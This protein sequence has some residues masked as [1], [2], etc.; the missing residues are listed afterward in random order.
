MIYGLIIYFYTAFLYLIKN[1]IVM[2]I[3]KHII[4]LNMSYQE[5]IMLYK[6]KLIGTNCLYNRFVYFDLIKKSVHWRYDASMFTETSDL[7]GYV[8]IPTTHNLLGPIKH[9][10]KKSYYVGDL[11]NEEYST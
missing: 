3:F 1:S 7:W 11:N 4:L 9:I 6:T 5:L 10:T 8:K 2:I